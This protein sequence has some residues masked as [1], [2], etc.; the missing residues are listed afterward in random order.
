MRMEPF[1][2]FVLAVAWSAGLVL[3][4]CD[5]EESGERNAS[6]CGR[7]HK[8]SAAGSECAAAR[9]GGLVWGPVERVMDGGNGSAAVLAPDGTATA[10][11]VGYSSQVFSREARPGQAWGAPQAVP[12]SGRVDPFLIADGDDRGNVTAVWTTDKNLRYTVWSAEHPAGGSW[13]KPVKLG[14]GSSEDIGLDAWDLAAGPSGAA[15]LAWNDADGGGFRVTYRER[16]RCLVGAEA[17]VR[18]VLHAD[19]DRDRRQRRPRH[20]GLPVWQ[21]TAAHIP[22]GLSR[23]VALA[24]SAADARRAPGLRHRD[25]PQRGVGRGRGRAPTTG[26]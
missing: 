12:D 5:S 15:V 1:R 9:G 17:A 4:G 11:W 16:R 19:T 13:S 3:C 20:G 24:G 2:V 26:S 22:G 14:D 25:W 10:V 8:D 23:G 18:C 7:G 21:Q 6:P